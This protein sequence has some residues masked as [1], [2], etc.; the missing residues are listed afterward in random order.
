MK[1]IDAH[2]HSW[3]IGAA[4]HQWPTTEESAIYRDF[5]AHDLTAEANTPHLVA[6]VLVQSQPDER[7]TLWM[8]EQVAD[9]PLVQAVVGWTEML[10]DD[11]PHRIAEL[12]KHNLLRGLRPMLQSITDTEWLLRDELAPAITAMIDHG[13][14]LDALV[15]PRH[16]PMLAAFTAR[17]PQLPIVIDH[18]AK[19]SIHAAPDAAWRD[20]MARLADLG[21][22]CKLSGLRTEQSPDQPAAMLTPY[23]QCLIDQYGPRL[24]WGSDW[25]V[26]HLAGDRWGD[27]Y[28]QCAAWAAGSSRAEHLFHGAA[29]EF[30]S[31]NIK[32]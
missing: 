19:P 22:W 3:Q 25:P 13:L 18:A 31:I 12:A 1:I 17:Y 8:L 21:L 27:W 24:M 11:A 10:A 26:L 2:H 28:K 30:Y 16:L 5:S 14:R 6:S 7:D 15:Q 29:A 23:A 32:G 4:H 20:D 9:Q